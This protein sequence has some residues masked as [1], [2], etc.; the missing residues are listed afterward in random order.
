MMEQIQKC[1][2]FFAFIWSILHRPDYHK[3]PFCKNTHGCGSPYVDRYVQ[4]THEYNQARQVCTHVYACPKSTYVCDLNDTHVAL[5]SSV[6]C[7]VQHKGNM[8]R[9]S[10]DETSLLEDLRTCKYSPCIGHYSC[11]I[12]CRQ[13]LFTSIYHT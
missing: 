6:T 9:Y 8:K 11:A 10:N 1:H 12:N 4:F 13:E 5:N 3:L 2:W 7:T